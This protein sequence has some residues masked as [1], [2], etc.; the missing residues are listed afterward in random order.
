M[1]RKLF[2][3][4]ELIDDQYIPDTI[5]NIGNQSIQCCTYYCCLTRLYVHCI[6]TNWHKNANSTETQKLSL[7]NKVHIYIMLSK[8]CKE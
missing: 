3:M 1:L 7:A 8:Y 2:G 5:K 6:A 4:P